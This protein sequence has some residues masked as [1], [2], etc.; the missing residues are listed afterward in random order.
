MELKARV[1][2][3]FDEGPMKAVMSMR[4]GELVI[5]RVRLVELPDGRL[6]LAMPC[7]KHRGK[8]YEQA[9]PMTEGLR[10]AMEEEAMRAYEAAKKSV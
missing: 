5:E 3:V 4:Y 8:Y 1:Y 6:I 9:W 10:T 2:R 7:R